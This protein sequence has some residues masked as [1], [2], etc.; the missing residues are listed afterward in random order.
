VIHG[1]EDVPASLREIQDGRLADLVVVCTGVIP[2]VE[3]ALESVERGG[4]ILFFAPTA[5]DAT[6]PIRINDLLF[7]EVTLTSSYSGSREDATIALDLIAAHRVRVK[8][9]V[10]HKFGLAETGK[11]FRVVAEAGKSIKVIIEP[12]K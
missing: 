10:T 4:T 5:P 2:A 1:N 12:Q 11:G 6:V 7:N 3:Q 8:E 9:M